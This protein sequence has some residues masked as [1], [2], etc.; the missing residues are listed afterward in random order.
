MRF[1]ILLSTTAALLAGTDAAPQSPEHGKAHHLEPRTPATRQGRLGHWAAAL[2]LRRLQAQVAHGYNGTNST[3]VTTK[4]TYVFPSQGLGYDAPSLLE[5]SPSVTKCAGYV[6]VSTTTVEVTQ[7]VTEGG[8]EDTTTYALGSEDDASQ[9]VVIGGSTTRTLSYKHETEAPYPEHTKPVFPPYQSLNISTTTTKSSNYGYAPY[10]GNTTTAF[11][12]YHSSNVSIATTKSSHAYES[13]TPY[14]KNTTPIFPTYQPANVST[15]TLGHKYDTDGPYAEPTTLVLPPYHSTN[16]STT[17][18]STYEYATGAPY[19]YPENTTPVF[20]SYQ[21]ANVSTV[22]TYGSEPSTTRTIDE[23]P[24]YDPHPPVTTLVVPPTSSTSLYRNVSDIVSVGYSSEAVVMSESLVIIESSTTVLIRETEVNVNPYETLPAYGPDYNIA[25]YEAPYDAVTTTESL[26]LPESSQDASI[27]EE[28]SSV[29][30]F[31]Y[32]ESSEVL[33]LSE[34]TLIF[35]SSGSSSL[36][37][38]QVTASYSD[39]V[40]ASESSIPVASESYVA[41]EETSTGT[42]SATDY[43]STYAATEP[44]PS[45]TGDC[46]IDTS[47]VP[48][49]TAPLTSLPATV[50]DPTKTVSEGDAPTGKPEAG[51]QHCGVHGKPVGNYFLARF[52][53]NSPGVPVTLEGCYQ[54]CDSVMDATEGC[55]SY[56]FYPERDLN[57]ARC[58]LYGSNVAYALNSV[59]DYYPDIWFDVDCG[60]PRSDRWAHLP[61]LERLESLGLE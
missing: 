35:E 2:R 3:T 9:I 21:S 34:S 11:P 30:T 26:V 41:S 19:P 10:Q 7:Y 59:D 42:F 8:S 25:N 6:F 45:K 60:S 4:P 32:G 31:A 40:Y 53:E 46:V 22:Q 55:E 36:S 54:F 50:E 47:I 48:V 61:G 14:A 29:Y 33:T 18:R 39:Q 37:E 28:P 44:L 23:Y 17:S 52:V 49:S 27:S 43:F 1:A 16:I 24:E 58:D 38:T 15:T 56:R 57:A 13:E 5:E 51:S 12:S 20:P